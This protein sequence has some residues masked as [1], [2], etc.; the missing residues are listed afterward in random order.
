LIASEKGYVQLR[1]GP[2]KLGFIG[3]LQPFSDAIKLF[4]KESMILERYNYLLYYFSP[5]L[6][7]SIMLIG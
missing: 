5:V 7:L 2:N 6:A 3:V 1:K 4:L